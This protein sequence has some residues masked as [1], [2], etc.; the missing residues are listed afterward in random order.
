MWLAKFIK[1]PEHQAE[2]V[3]DL[4]FSESYFQSWHVGMQ[5]IRLEDLHQTIQ[6][7]NPNY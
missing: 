4:K 6:L 2:V 1:A 5:S 3:W 7:P